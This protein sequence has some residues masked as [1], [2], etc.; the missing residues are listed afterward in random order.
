M[1]G[2]APYTGLVY[3]HTPLTFNVVLPLLYC[4]TPCTAPC[5]RPNLKPNPNP[6]R[7][8]TL[9]QAL[10]LERYG[11]E[12][13]YTGRAAPLDADSIAASHS[14][15]AGAS[16]SVVSHGDILCV[17][18]HTGRL[19]RLMPAATEVRRKPEPQPQP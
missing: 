17:R 4:N 12:A 8:L 19:L 10:R 1:A 6:K 11:S 15:A 3:C 18:A 16:H 2:T 13:S 14:D 7:N 5:G 9:W